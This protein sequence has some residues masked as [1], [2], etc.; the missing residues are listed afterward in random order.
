MEYLNTKWHFTPFE[1]NNS[2]TFSIEKRDNEFIMNISIIKD[3]IEENISNKFKKHDLLGIPF[4]IVIGSK[5]KKD[6]YEFKEIDKESQM[7]SL[8]EIIKLLK[9]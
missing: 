7:L 6:V 8:I 4:Q 5:A 9:K 2:F 3:D 1:E